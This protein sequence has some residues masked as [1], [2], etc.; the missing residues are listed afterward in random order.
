MHR[1]TEH[2]VAQF[3]PLGVSERMS[4][5]KQLI[6]V[7]V[8]VIFSTYVR[9]HG[10]VTQLWNH[11][12]ETDYADRLFIDQNGFASVRFDEGTDHFKNISLLQLCFLL[13]DLGIPFAEDYTDLWSPAEYMKELQRQHVLRKP[14][15]SIAARSV[16]EPDWRCIE[17]EADT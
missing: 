2:G 13:N 16:N 14:F 11:L 1:I 3:K 17:H 10:D 15:N 6:P 7:H 4:T 12:R 5:N 9:L 8:A